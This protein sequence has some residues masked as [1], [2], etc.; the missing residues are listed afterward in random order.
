MS[1]SLG[2]NLDLFLLGPRTVSSEHSA[3]FS[4]LWTGLDFSEKKFHGPSYLHTKEGKCMGLCLL[5][6]AAAPILI[7]EDDCLSSGF[8]PHPGPGNLL[9]YSILTTSS[10]GSKHHNYHFNH[11]TI[12]FSVTPEQLQSATSFL[13]T[14]L[15]PG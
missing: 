14:E 8:L 5:K 15:D 1:H 10:S 12:L 9:V 13:T 6:N 3:L 2:F 11:F 7:P 4:R